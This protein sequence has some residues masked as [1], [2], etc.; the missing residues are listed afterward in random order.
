MNSFWKNKKVLVTGASGF[1]GSHTIDALLERGA[2]V[3]AIV[4][5]K[6]G[7]EKIKRNLGHVLKQAKII[8]ADLL[9]LNECLKITHNQ[10]AVFNF[11]AMDGGVYFKMKYPA[12]IFRTNSQIT[13]NMLEAARQ[14]KANRF[15]LISSIEVYPGN[16]PSRVN[17]KYGSREGLDEKTEGYSW[18]KRFGEV[19]AKMYHKEHGMNIAVARLGNV[20]GPRDYS[21]KEKGRVI[22]TF[23][24]QSLQGQDIRVAG[25]GMQERAF[26]YVADLVEA[27]LNLMEKYAVCDPVNVASDKYI[28][29]RD[30]AGLVINIIGKNNKLTLEKS[31]I[32]FSRKRRISVNKAKKVI[33]L[34]EKETIE[35]GLKKTI[36]FFTNTAVE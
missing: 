21:D 1:I 8:K 31:D 23:I 32:S 9:S 17:E 7:K 34:K 3:T 2:I 12:K 13:L 27:L 19:A 16:L 20:Y 11:A 28:T 15:L 10:N 25:D 30:L 22:P 14:N 35:T 5:P 18:S 36:N 4:S 6:T 26:L 33:R 24:S 29:I